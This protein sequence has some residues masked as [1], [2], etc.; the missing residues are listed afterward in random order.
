MPRTQRPRSMVTSPRIGIQCRGW[1]RKQGD[2]PLFETASGTLLLI[3]LLRRREGGVLPMHR[4]RRGMTVIELLVV[5]AIIAVL[6]GLLFPAIQHARESANL[7]ACANNLKQ[8]GLA[9]HGYHD[10]N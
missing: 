5:M 2:C 8:L 3:L 7:A 1:E 4:N 9:L 6:I 10:A